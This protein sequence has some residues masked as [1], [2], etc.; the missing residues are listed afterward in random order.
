M[1][2]QWQIGWV[3]GRSDT[4]VLFGEATMGLEGGKTKLV[5]GRG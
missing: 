2:A 1:I 3:D 4:G 5:R